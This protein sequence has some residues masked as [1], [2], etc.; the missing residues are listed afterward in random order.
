MKLPVVV[1]FTG[2]LATVG[3]PYGWQLIPTNDQALQSSSLRSRIIRLSQSGELLPSEGTRAGLR[4]S[5]VP[6]VSIFASLRNHVTAPGPLQ[7]GDQVDCQCEL[8][9]VDRFEDFAIRLRTS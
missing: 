6:I 2:L 5:F 9:G 4:S 1:F 7:A 8:L 3:L